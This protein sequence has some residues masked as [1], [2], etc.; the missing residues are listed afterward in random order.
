MYLGD[1]STSIDLISPPPSPLIPPDSITESM[2]ELDIEGGPG[3]RES[4][5]GEGGDPPGGDD[6]IDSIFIRGGANGG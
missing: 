3:E 2:V 1:L 6:S 5:R 4:P